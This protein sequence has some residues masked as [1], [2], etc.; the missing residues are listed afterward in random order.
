[1]SVNLKS[2]QQNSVTLNNREKI[3]KKNRAT[4]TCETMT[5]YP[6]LVSSESTKETR[7]KMGLKKNDKII[8]ENFPKLVKYTNIQIQE[9]E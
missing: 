1:M 9:S 2:E 7:R 4:G 5:E 3:Y 8:A 6:A